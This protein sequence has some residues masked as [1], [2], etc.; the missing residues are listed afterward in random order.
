MASSQNLIN[1]LLLNLD[2]LKIQTENNEKNQN[3]N[4]SINLQEQLDLLKSETEKLT[5]Q[6]TRNTNKKTRKLPP[7][8]ITGKG[9]FSKFQT[10][11]DMLN[12]LNN[13]TYGNKN[14]KSAKG[15][16]NTGTFIDP[17]RF[18]D[19]YKYTVLST[20]DETEDDE[21]SSN[22]STEYTPRTPKST[23]P[24]YS[25][26][27]KEYNNINCNIINNRK[28]SVGLL[29]PT[30]YT[31]TNNTSVRSRS[32]S[33]S[34][35]EKYNNIIKNTIHEGSNMRNEKRYSFNCLQRINEGVENE[36]SCQKVN[37]DYIKPP[38]SSSIQN[39]S[40][41]KQ[42]IEDSG[43][44]TS[45]SSEPCSEKVLSQYH[46]MGDIAYI[47]YKNPSGLESKSSFQSDRTLV[48]DEEWFIQR[49]KQ[50]YT[51]KKIKT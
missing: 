47:K 15:R 43:S 14:P 16:K 26:K 8:I 44:E 37:F 34:Q 12:E 23:F 41:S 33:Y 31:S 49:T 27:N 21:D 5:N 18:S 35:P 19:P 46:V 29:S 7:P 10:I 40:L 45:E 3:V 11:D 6:Y 25:R 51:Q 39:R 32:R 17:R 22:E 36:K 9:K 50:K 2:N 24:Y 42:I 48:N 38:R 13:A 4:D 20:L 28:L 1:N 30:G